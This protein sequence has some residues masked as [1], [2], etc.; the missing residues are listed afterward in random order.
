MLGI[1]K[2]DYHRIDDTI[3]VIYAIVSPADIESTR[4]QDHLDLPVTF[5]LL[6]ELYS[7]GLEAETTL[8]EVSARDQ[9]TG[10]FLSNLNRRMELIARAATERDLELPGSTQ[11]ARIGEGGVSFVTDELLARGTLLALGL[12]FRPE[13]LGLVAFGE[14]RHSRLSDKDENYIAGVRFTHMDD[15][16]QQLI[17]RHIIHRQSI[18][19]RERLKHS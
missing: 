6:R 2:R 16:F 4:P 15:D 19:R 18:E 1:E 13:M 12:R 17:A 14:V 7:L 8:R 5:G 11:S 10:K 3:G 9:Q